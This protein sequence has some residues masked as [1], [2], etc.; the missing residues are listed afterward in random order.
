[1]SSRGTSHRFTD[2]DDEGE[3]I[4][5]HGQT[6]SPAGPGNAELSELLGLSGDEDAA[7]RHRD[8]LGYGVRMT[9]PAE[10]RALLEA[11]FAQ[12]GGA[13]EMVGRHAG[14]DQPH[15]VRAVLFLLARGASR[16]SLGEPAGPLVMTAVRA[17]R[18][19]DDA[20]LVNLLSAVQLA[21][22]HRE[23]LEPDEPPPPELLALLIRSASRS[24]LV[25]SALAATVASLHARGDL[26][27]AD[28]TQREELRAALAALSATPD[29]LLEMELR[30]LAP[31]LGA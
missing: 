23:L 30:D 9:D 12:P 28:P 18:C 3:E 16:Q 4:A 29:S 27:R 11:R 20:A 24:E 17:L 1:M 7:G 21:S 22:M 8:H 31:F 26:E 19:D 2:G 5:E 13:A 10:E 15:L 6:P 14:S 25:Q